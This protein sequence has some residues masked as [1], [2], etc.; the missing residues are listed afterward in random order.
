MKSTSIDEL[1]LQTIFLVLGS[2]DLIYRLSIAVFGR[3]IG[4]NLLLLYVLASFVGFVLSVM[5]W[6]LNSSI[7]MNKA[8]SLLFAMCPAVFMSLMYPINSELTGP[9]K[10]KSKYTI[11]VAVS[12]LGVILGPVLSGF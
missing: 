5:W 7:A 1:S 6:S 10:M 8:Y 3:F 9:S 11:N 12:G 4:Q 2:A